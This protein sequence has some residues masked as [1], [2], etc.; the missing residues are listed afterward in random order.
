MAAAAAAYYMPYESSDSGGSSEESDADDA[1]WSE[2]SDESE[3]DPRY[4]IH[5]AAG[6]TMADPKLQQM[7]SMASGGAGAAP[8]D[9]TT[10]ITSLENHVYLDPPKT[11]KTSL[12]SI[13]SIDRD[14][15]VWPTPYNF[16][17]K[18]P[19]TY[20]NITKFQMVQMSFPNNNATN[21]SQVSLITSTIVQNLLLKGVPSTC[22]SDCIGVITCTTGAHALALL[23]SGR[24]NRAGDPLLVT[25]SVADGSYEDA[26]V[27]RELTFRANATPPLDVIPYEDFR[28]A[29][30]VTRDASILFAEPGGEGFVSAASNRRIHGNHTKDD[31]MSV[32]YTQQHIDSLPEITDTIALVAYY[33][34]VLKELLATQRAEPFLRIPGGVTYLEVVER[35]M[36]FF[37]GLDSEF[38]AEVCRLNRDA[39]DGY[40]RH[41]T[42]ETRNINRYQVL[43]QPAESRFRVVHD[44][45]HPSIQRDLGKRYQFA[46]T[47]QLDL[48]GLHSTG[49]QTLKDRQRVD[50]SI[51]HHLKTCMESLLSGYELEPV[52]YQRGTAD[53]RCYTV[54][55][56]MGGGTTRYTAEELV[57][58]AKGTEFNGAEATEYKGA[59][60]AP[61]FKGASAPE[62]KGARMAPEFNGLF[63]GFASSFGGI[64]GTYSGTVMR[65]STFMDYHSTLEG[66]SARIE[67]T[68]RVVSTIYGRVEHEYHTYVSTKYATVLPAKMIETRSYGQNQGVAVSMIQGDSV[69]IPGTSLPFSMPSSAPAA[70]G[71][72]LITLQSANAA[73]AANAIAYNAAD[74]AQICCSTVRGW[75]KS[76][77]SCL[78]TAFVIRTLQ[79]RLGV[80]DVYPTSFNL[81]STILNITSTGNLNYLLKINDEQ[82]FNNMDL[83]MP[84]N[85]QVTNDT[86]GQVKMVAAKIL[87][88]GVGDTGISQTVI[89]NPSLFENTLGK[90]DRL[91]FKIYYDDQSLTPAWLYLPYYLDL[92]EWNATFQVDEEVGNANRATGWGYKPTV[93]V[94]A[95]PNQTPYLFFTHR[96]NPNNS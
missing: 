20:K 51:C 26:A 56:Q 75:V 60:T 67:E 45:L 1:P 18:L 85:Y 15:S 27:A 72:N 63:D 9:T 64:F 86:T 78:P 22:I 96:D 37:E 49:F 46:L 29:F 88:A 5:R 89:Q 13:K 91:S 76:W 65:F 66:Y 62:Y 35:V 84:E 6:P 83:S 33:Y 3:V 21:A 53:G 23:E 31:M 36:G 69:F 50:S 11:T 12:I 58:S 87:M 93:P 34:P 40:R 59:V 48:A 14:K 28:V 4:A 47:Q 71:N 42:F 81:I 10:N 61:E 44:R 24:T 94:P 39:L 16:Q 95:D 32:Y 90:L 2:I 57:S 92:T 82:G 43:H 41:L 77:Y 80:M 54:E 7:Y 8:F 74:C 79:Y 70:L 68:Q 73:S 38:Y 55:H 30:R 25:L 52:T 19:R 17:I